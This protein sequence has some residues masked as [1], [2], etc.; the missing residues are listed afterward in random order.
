MTRAYTKA[1]P[2]AKPS[3]TSSTVVPAPVDW[4][5]DIYALLRCWPKAGPW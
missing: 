5:Q 2:K 4:N 3:A 1:K